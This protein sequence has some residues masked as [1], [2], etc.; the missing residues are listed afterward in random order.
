MTLTAQYKWRTAVGQKDIEIYRKENDNDD[1]SGTLRKNVTAAQVTEL[2][3][4]NRRIAIR[5]LPFTMGI[6]K[7]TVHATARFPT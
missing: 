5:N 1:R 3:L 2:V 4:G 6:V 7:R